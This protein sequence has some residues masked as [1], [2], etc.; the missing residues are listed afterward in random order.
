MRQFRNL[1][2]QQCQRPATCTTRQHG[3]VCPPGGRPLLPSGQRFASRR[4]FLCPHS[5]RHRPHPRYPSCR[6]VERCVYRSLS[7]GPPA[8]GPGYA[9]QHVAAV[10]HASPTVN[11]QVVGRQVVRKVLARHDRDA[12]FSARTLAQQ[13]GQLHT[14][15]V[16]G[17]RCVSTSLGDKNVRGGSKF[18]YPPGTGHVVAN[19]ALMA[20]K[21]HRERGQAALGRLASL[22]LGKGLRVGDDELWRNRQRGQCLSHALDGAAQ[23]KTTRIEQL[24]Q[25]LHLRQDEPS[26]RSLRSCGMTS[27]TVSPSATRW[28]TMSTSSATASQAKL[29][30]ASSR[31]SMPQRRKADTSTGRCPQ[32]SSKRDE[33]WQGSCT[34]STLFSTQRTGMPLSRNS[35]AHC[36]SPE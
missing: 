22:H 6:T 36:N 20:G 17:R 28:R 23:G 14:S 8:A 4:A 19:V 7:W 33:A 25:G 30:R 5:V 15:N 1:Q 34:R 11:H 12:Q 24:A 21:E 29:R 32:A 2:G 26:A 35:S 9:V 18:V 13:T 27:S 10:E 16:L 3:Q 31:R